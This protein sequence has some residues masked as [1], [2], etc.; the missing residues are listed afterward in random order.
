M[1]QE[2]RH[3]RIRALLSMLDR[4]SNERIMADLAYRA[5]TVRR[6]LLDL[7]ARAS[8]GAC[9]AAPIKPSGDEAP[10]PSAL[11]ANVNV[12][13]GHREG[14]YGVVRDGQTFSST[15]ARPRPSSPTN[16]RSSP[17]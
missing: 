16:S 12:E 6:D 7:E 14:G 2:D 1:W 5:E 11:S 10:S 9:M 4:V 8:C 13:E 17:I 3:Q 15:P